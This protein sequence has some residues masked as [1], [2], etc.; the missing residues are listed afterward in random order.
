M[1]LSRRALVAVGLAAAATPGQLMGQ[2]RTSTT[3]HWQNLLRPRHTHAAFALLRGPNRALLV[4]LFCRPLAT[5]PQPLPFEARGIDIAEALRSL[6]T[7]LDPRLGPPQGA[8]RGPR[9]GRLVMQISLLRRDA[10][11]GPEYVGGPVFLPT[12]QGRAG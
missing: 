2:W 8:R 7:E 6:P 5:L 9:E 3:G 4:G 12:A 10:A 1:S 11:G